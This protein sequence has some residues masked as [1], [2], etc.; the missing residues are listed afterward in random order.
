[1]AQLLNNYNLLLGASSIFERSHIYTLPFHR[2]PSIS[3]IKHTARSNLRMSQPGSTQDAQRPG[4]Q[5][6]Q[7]CF[8]FFGILFFD[9]SFWFERIKQYPCGDDYSNLE[10]KIFF[11]NLKMDEFYEYPCGY[12]SVVCW[13]LSIE[14]EI[15]LL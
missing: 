12:A 8:L 13:F 5:N 6:H 1:M 2:F 9:C 7:L 10:I 4:E 3:P 11:K 15:D 14:F